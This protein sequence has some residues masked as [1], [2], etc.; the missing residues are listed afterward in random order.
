MLCTS[1]LVIPEDSIHRRVNLKSHTVKGNF[2]FGHLESGIGITDK[3]N[4]AKE[5]EPYKPRQR[6]REQLSKYCWPI[7]D[8][9]GVFCWGRPE[10]I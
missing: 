9:N 10:A 1:S 5:Y 6:I 4:E 7:N 3:T 2:N 8:G